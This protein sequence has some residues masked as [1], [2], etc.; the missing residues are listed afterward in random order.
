MKFKELNIKNIASIEEAQLDFSAVPLSDAGVFLICGAT[1]AGKSTILD[2]ICLALYNT[3][4]RF[5]SQNGN[6]L[7]E[8]DMSM[9][10]VRQ[11]L[12][13]GA[14]Y[15]SITLEFTGNNSREYRMEWCAYRA[16]KKATGKIQAVKWTMTDIGSGKKLEKIRDIERAVGEATGM[17]FE[18][19]CRTTMLAQGDFTRFLKSD[20]KEKGE[21]LSRLTG[22]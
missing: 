13:R 10:D 14:G 5:S 17:Q 12:R 4:P 11:I 18:Q 9:K 2:A 15:G 3:T 6:E 7:P 1:G 21:I 16:H 19:F 8:G 20:D 22:V